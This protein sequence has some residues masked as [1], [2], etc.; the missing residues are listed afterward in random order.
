MK[1]ILF[2]VA[3]GNTEQLFN[4]LLPRVPIAS[5]TAL[6]SFDILVNPTHDAGNLN[7]SHEYLRPFIK[8]YR[9]AVVVFDHE[10]CGEENKSPEDLE[11]TVS[12]QLD[13][14]G[15]EGR[16]KVLVIE[17]ELENW[18]WM[19]SPKLKEA[20]NWKSNEELHS[21]VANKGYLFN[22]NSKPLRPKEAFEAALRQARTPRSSSIYKKIASIVSYKSC[23][24]RAF[25]ELI[26]TLQ[27]WF[28]KT[29]PVAKAWT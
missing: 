16:N 14:N 21:W 13:K 9:F 23:N 2:L 11:N 5:N 20:I 10:G 7:D 19:G 18:I 3:D 4:G 12:K 17:P 15:W 28:C 6:F 8:Q 22:E 29:T 27:E 25:L 24:D 26:K 1:D